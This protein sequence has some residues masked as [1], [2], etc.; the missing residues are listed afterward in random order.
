V[1]FYVPADKYRQERPDPCLFFQFFQDLAVCPL[2]HVNGKSKFPGQPLNGIGVEIG[3][4]SLSG[5]LI[6]SSV[7]SSMLSPPWCG[8]SAFLLMRSNDA[9]LRPSR[10]QLFR[11]EQRASVMIVRAAVGR[12]L[13]DAH[14]DL[15]VR[16]QA[17]RFGTGFKIGAHELLQGR[18][19]L[20][21]GVVG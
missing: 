2:D 14:R 6:P 18:S 1:F 9:M 13:P 20:I 11:E 7:W 12:Y 4:F 15:R 21:D 5:W 3:L 10:Q 17:S 19:D 16:S 8:E